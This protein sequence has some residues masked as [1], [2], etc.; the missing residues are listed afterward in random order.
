M[1]GARA[2]GRTGPAGP[3]PAGSGPV[4]APSVQAT[5]IS[6]AARAR[7]AGGAALPREALSCGR[8]PRRGRP[9]C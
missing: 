7:G 5:T 8:D 2:V 6:V 3:S 9:L 1:S 4:G